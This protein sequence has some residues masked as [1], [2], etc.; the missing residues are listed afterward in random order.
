VEHKSIE[1]STVEL[2]D[3]SS[4]GITPKN[5]IFKVSVSQKQIKGSE[6]IK[7]ISNV[8]TEGNLLI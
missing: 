6:E 3:K 8:T 7:L 4:E 5:K 2:V 1:D